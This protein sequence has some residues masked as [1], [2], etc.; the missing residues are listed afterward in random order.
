MRYHPR[1]TL[2]ERDFVCERLRGF[3][4]LLLQNM[5]GLNHAQWNFKPSEK[6]WSIAQCVE[7]LTEVEIGVNDSI[8]TLLFNGTG[9]PQLCAEAKGKERLLLRA[10]PNRTRHAEAPR[11][12]ANNPIFATQPIAERAFKDV[13]SRTLS[14]AQSTEHDL[15]KYVMPHFVFG[16]LNIYQW[17][18]MLSL[19]CERHAAQII[20]IKEDPGFPPA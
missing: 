12:P 3:L 2:D 7:H 20:E 11:Q 5:E 10:V 13:R 4:Q 19:H 17:L 8:Q 16:Q 18:L 6:A 14:F 15:E 1:M 9:D